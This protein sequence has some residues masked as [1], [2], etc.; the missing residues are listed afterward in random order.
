MDTMQLMIIAGAGVVLAAIGVWAG[1]WSLAPRE[2]EL[3]QRIARLE[4]ARQTAQERSQ[5]AR[6]QIEI[7]Q[8]EISLHHKARSEALSAHKRARDL[9]DALD[10]EQTLVLPGRSNDGFSL[11]RLP[12]SGFAD[13]QPA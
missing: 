7:L 13:T 1:R 5:Q 9:S 10:A 3:M 11:S 2:A 6:R 4:K 8:Q 12:P